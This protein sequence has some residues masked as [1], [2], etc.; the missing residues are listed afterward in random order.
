ML[1]KLTALVTLVLLLFSVA[2]VQA[3]ASYGDVFCGDLSDADC[4][5][6]LDNAA[7]MDEIQSLSFSANLAFEV[8]EAGVE[9]YFVMSGAGSGRLAFDPAAAVALDDPANYADPAGLAALMESFFSSMAGELSFD[10]RGESA[11]EDISLQLNMK[12]RDGLIVFDGAALEALTGESMGDVQWFGMD[13]TGAF[14]DI[15]EEAGMD[16]EGMA[17]LA[18]MEAAEH[19]FTTITRLPDELVGGVTVAVFH[20][21]LDLNAIL[22]GMTMEDFGAQAGTDQLQDVQLAYELMQSF[23]VAEFSYRQY[24][25]LDDRYT[26][27]TDV[28]MNMLM[29]GDALG[30]GNRDLS[31]T[32]QLDMHLSDFDQSFDVT[33]PEDAFILPLAMFS[34]MGS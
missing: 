18:A 1:K 5:I 22:S 14:A 34:Q 20:S 10:L 24:I 15:I 31:M 9:G 30:V 13:T 28:S 17:S 19:D 27:R 12:M 4:Q 33:I 16:E 11:E 6:L 25:G 7:V 32:M 3:D 26:Y 21:S 2:A 8:G 29:P 23:E